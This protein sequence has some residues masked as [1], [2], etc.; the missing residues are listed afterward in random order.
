MVSSDE[1]WAIG[2]DDGFAGVGTFL[3][4]YH[5]GTWAREPFPFQ[6][7]NANIVFSPTAIAMISAQEGWAGG[8]LHD[9]TGA[10]A[11]V[12]TIFHFAGGAWRQEALPAGLT[13]IQAL[14][15]L[16]PDAGWALGQTNTSSI[17]SSQILRYRGG[18]WITE[19]T[20]AVFPNASLMTISMASATDG[21]AAGGNLLLRYTNGAWSPTTPPPGPGVVSRIYTSVSM[22]SPT[23]GWAAAIDQTPDGTCTEC[24]GGGS[25][26]VILRYADGA[27]QKWQPASPIPSAGG[28]GS[29]DAINSTTVFAVTGDQVWVADGVIA[30]Y[31]V[32]QPVEVLRSNCDSLLVKIAPISGAHEAWIIGTQGQL[33]HYLNGT[34]TR[35]E[36]GL[37]CAPGGG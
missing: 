10:Q 11:D 34:L 22:A 21:W 5:Q 14:A 8:A 30:H 25:T 26:L 4:H 13:T 23:T 9:S 33:F 2:H 12:A 15:M 20:R 35:Y 36:T 27:W 17:Q 3:L 32:G 37:P 7:T 19:I 1:G 24:G 29:D 31:A 16:A 18:R 28:Y 6:S